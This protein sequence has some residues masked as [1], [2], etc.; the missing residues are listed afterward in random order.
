MAVIDVNG[1]GYGVFIP[2]RIA[3]DRIREGLEVKIY[4]VTIAS[5]DNLQLF[6]FL[7]PLDREF[8]QM[9]LK[10]PRIGPKGAM[11][12]LSS[13]PA[14]TIMQIILSGDRKKL[15]GFP[16]IGKKAAQRI[17][18]ELQDKVEKLVEKEKI[19]R[20]DIAG[21]VI[22]VLVGL[23]CKPAEARD[24]VLK[25]KETIP[26]KIDFDQ[27]LNKALERMSEEETG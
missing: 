27:L 17:I 4:T 3:G 26:E 12:I 13:S 9:L 5:Q 18:F 25:V 6:G 19:P 23:G 7:S 2:E 22:D 20:E 8:F 15:S 1:V 10:I 14:S 21:E 24:V 11:K 16:G